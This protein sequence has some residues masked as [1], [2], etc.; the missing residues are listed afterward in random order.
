MAGVAKRLLFAARAPWAARSPRYGPLRPRASDLDLF[1]P[2]TLELNGDIRLVAVDGENSWVD[3]GFG[4]LRSGSDGDFRVRPQLGNVNLIW[5]P[6]FTWS[7]SATVVG[8]LQG[9]ERTEAG[10]S[11]AY[12]TLQADAR[13][14]RSLSRPA[15]A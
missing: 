6:Q 14:A 8:S 15:P 10:L 7:L 11:Q 5:Q 3:G 2:D 12:L 9:G 1:S 13:D 4:K